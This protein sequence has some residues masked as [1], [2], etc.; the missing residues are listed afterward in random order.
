M[1]SPA[2]STCAR[3][4]AAAALLLATASVQA[5][6]FKCQQDSGLVTYS[7]K[8][9]HIKTTL[10][11]VKSIDKVEDEMPSAASLLRALGPD[12]AID[13]SGRV[14]TRVPGGYVDK[15]GLRIPGVAQGHR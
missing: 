8:P 2:T 11:D 9:C 4:L 14:Y 3:T 10:N 7:D 5:Q 1:S 12:K 6:V 13:K 15:Y